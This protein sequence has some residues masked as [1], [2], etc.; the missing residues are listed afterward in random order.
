MDPTLDNLVI[1]VQEKTLKQK[2][3]AVNWITRN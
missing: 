1:T 2:D 3:Q